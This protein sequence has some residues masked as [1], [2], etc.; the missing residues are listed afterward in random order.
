MNFYS[1]RYILIQK[2]IQS[3]T[4]LIYIYVCASQLHVSATPM[5]P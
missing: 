2:W 1:D 5:W 3:N 4:Q